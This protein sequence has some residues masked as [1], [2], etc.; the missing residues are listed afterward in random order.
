MT[1]EIEPQSGVGRPDEI[2]RR[3]LLSGLAGGAALAMSQNAQAEE[4]TPS[5][6]P[7]KAA[8]GSQLS[9][10]VAVITGAARG[11]RPGHRRGAGGERS[12]HRRH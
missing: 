11:H 12:R 5:A 3:L 8:R 7:I 1:I 10:K 6:G 4:K 2:R 9:E